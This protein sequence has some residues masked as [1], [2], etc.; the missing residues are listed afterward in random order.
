MVFQTIQ[1]LESCWRR[2][3]LMVSTLDVG[4]RVPGSSPGRGKALH[5]WARHF[6][7]TVGLSS[8]RFINGTGEF[9]AGSYRAMD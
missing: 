6:T 5:S 9:T 2:S 7:L 8:P 1:K 4:W 3:G